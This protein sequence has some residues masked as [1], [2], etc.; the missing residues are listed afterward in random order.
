MN[1]N[2]TIH[3]KMNLC[4]IA[5]IFLL[6]AAF[7]T[8]ADAWAQTYYTKLTN[9]NGTP[10]TANWTSANAN[11]WEVEVN[12]VRSP[13]TNPPTSVNP[14][15]IT[16]A[17]TVPAGQTALCKS[18]SIS[19]TTSSIK[20]ILGAGSSVD[21]KENVIVNSPSAPADSNSIEIRQA[22]LTI[23]QALIFGNNTNNSNKGFV[24][25]SVKGPDGSPGIL[26][27]KGNIAN[28][29]TS[30]STSICSLRLFGY[31]ELE[32][33][34][35]LSI[36]A[37]L[38]GTFP[39]NSI[40]RF[41]G[42]IA[43]SLP[44]G[45]VFGNVHIANSAGVYL[46]EGLNTSNLLGDLV[47]E[48]GQL[49]DRGFSIAGKTGQ[50]GKNLEV[51]AGAKL[52]LSYSDLTTNNAFPTGFVNINLDPASTVVYNGTALQKVAAKDYG[53]LEFLGGA[54]KQK[55][56]LGYTTAKNVNVAADLF[57]DLGSLYI[58][59][60]TLT[61]TTTGSIN[62]PSSSRYII[63][64]PTGKMLVKSMGQ[65][66]GAR[67]TEFTFPIGNSTNYTPAYLKSWGTTNDFAIGVASGVKDYFNNVSLNQNIVNRTW[68]VECVNQTG[69]PNVELRL[70][71]NADDEMSNFDNTACYVTHYTNNAWTKSDLFQNGLLGGRSVKM[72]GITTFSPFSVA[73][74][75]NPL[76]VELVFFKAAKKDNGA[77]LT[78]ETASEKNCQG[79][80][81]LV[82]SDGKNFEAIGYV[83]SKNGNA[84]FA[85]RYEFL[86]KTSRSGLV[87]YRLKQTD[88]DGKIAYYAA[89]V[90]NM[91]KFTETLTAFPNPFQNQFELKV[92]V[93]T[94]QEVQLVIAD[95]TGKTVYQKAVKVPAGES[96]V[97]MELNNNLPG[98]LYILTTKTIEKLHTTRLIKQ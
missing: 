57:L 82:S 73:D 85:Q 32:V 97:P 10:N 77:L 41:N 51:W 92:Q 87:Y 55:F 47:V 96:L 9:P 69:F 11:A 29:S 68:N 53:N 23:G 36:G 74:G 14:V 3:R 50:N 65:T 90:L 52:I 1:A 49:E 81:V 86:D 84:N 40:V 46:T 38:S 6:L 95:M 4:R 48:S 43:Q 44:T 78:W 83:A 80:D 72:T 19:A 42:D 66:L 70:Q 61:L 67:S 18:M 71:W 56:L 22:T 20:L 8:S 31:S 64:G 37:K 30:N 75:G 16:R 24:D 58:G 7:L 89:N 93:A 13:A 54:G 39:A 79:Y 25:V 17:I 98:G 91:G 45:V 60:N 26:K 12:G 63:L 59:N 2:F 27:V 34:A 28:P 35:S 76:P 15:V 62:N 33:G 88:L 94:S 5:A 21:V